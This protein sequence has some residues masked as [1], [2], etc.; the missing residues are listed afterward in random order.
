[1][2]QVYPPEIYFWPKKLSHKHHQNQPHYTINIIFTRFFPIENNP[3]KNQKIEDPEG[4][5]IKIPFENVGALA[6][7]IGTAASSVNSDVLN[8]SNFHKI[9]IL[10]NFFTDF[11]LILQITKCLIYS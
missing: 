2:L 10:S 6:K 11:R 9:L 5:G 4:L 8:L 7:N 1:M 3:K